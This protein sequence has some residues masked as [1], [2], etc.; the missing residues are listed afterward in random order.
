MPKATEAG[1]WCE[2]SADC[3]SRG[4]F[5]RKQRVRGEARRQLGKAEEER[6]AGR[7]SV[8]QCGER[9][10]KRTSAGLGEG[11][12]VESSESEPGKRAW[13]REGRK[14]GPRV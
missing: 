3:D 2:R 9:N 1:L 6:V 13:I 10:E 11:E 14:T 7:K 4:A 5:T 12:G 8:K